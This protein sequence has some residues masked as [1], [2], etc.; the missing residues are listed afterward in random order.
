M[1][2]RD[3]CISTNRRYINWGAII[4]DK[5]YMGVG[6]V[7]SSLKEEFG[8]YNTLLKIMIPKGTKGLYIDLIS[9]RGGEQELLCARGSK[10]KVLFT[11][12]RRK[13]NIIIC[14]MLKSEEA[15]KSEE[16]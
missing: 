11:Y 4:E 7:K 2:Y 8:S 15:D 5:G 13:K 16:I 12:R 3:L 14:K 9:N 1:D 10:L 6:L